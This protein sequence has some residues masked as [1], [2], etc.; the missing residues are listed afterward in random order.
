[1][2]IYCKSTDVSNEIKIFL[3]ARFKISNLGRFSYFLC[4]NII[5]DDGKIII[6]QSTYMLRVYSLGMAMRTLILYQ[7]LPMLVLL[8]QI[9]FLILFYC[10]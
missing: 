8:G 10:I 3:S 6:N 7:L 2:Q 1:M 5:Q 4:V 9:R